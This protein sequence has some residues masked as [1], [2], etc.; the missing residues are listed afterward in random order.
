MGSKWCWPESNRGEGRESRRLHDSQS[1]SGNNKSFPTAEGCKRGAVR[2]KVERYS[3]TVLL[4]I[5][6]LCL[7]CGE[8]TW[9]ETRIVEVA[10]CAGKQYSRKHIVRTV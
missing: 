5:T 4:M 8:H 6:K 3:T 2:R 7:L 1:L 10:I 9:G